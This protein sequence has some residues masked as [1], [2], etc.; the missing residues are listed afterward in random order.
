MA[1]DIHS[2]VDAHVLKARL[3]KLGSTIP[4]R[5]GR[6][7]C[8]RR[9]FWRDVMPFTVCASGLLAYTHAILA[10]D[11]SATAS[12]NSATFNRQKIVEF[13]RKAFLCVTVNR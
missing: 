2:L 13:V 3:I 4:S 1:G 5:L 11:I 10:T 6:I 9:A 8:E 12:V 7:A